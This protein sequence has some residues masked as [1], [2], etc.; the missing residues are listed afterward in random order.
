MYEAKQADT[1]CELIIHLPLQRVML[2]DMLENAAD[3]LL[4]DEGRI[5]LHF[6]PFEVKTLRLIRKA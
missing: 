1:T 2:C 5:T 4:P 6:H 3:Q